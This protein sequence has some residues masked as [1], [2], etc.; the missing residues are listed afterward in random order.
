MNTDTINATLKAA[1]ANLTDVKLVLELDGSYPVLIHQTIQEGTWTE[2][3]RFVFSEWSDMTVLIE[4]F[5]ATG[6][7]VTHS[8][9]LVL[10]IQ[11]EPIPSL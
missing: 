2:V 1:N 3:D 9:A 7:L 11:Q 10:L 6:Q 4:D 5:L 8:M